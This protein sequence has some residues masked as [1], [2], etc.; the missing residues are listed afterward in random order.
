[1]TMMKVRTPSRW[2]FKRRAATHNLLMH[3]VHGAD[4]LQYY[5]CAALGSVGQRLRELS[6]ALKIRWTLPAR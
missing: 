3:F 6:T 2:R 5:D 1:M 4:R